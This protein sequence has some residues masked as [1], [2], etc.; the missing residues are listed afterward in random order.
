M[1]ILFVV[2]YTPTL[3]RA[4]SY[5]FI[6]VLVDRGHCVT[7]ATLWESE[8][9]RLALAE[10]ASQGIAVIAE[11]LTKPQILVNMVCALLSRS[12]IQASFSW[13]PGLAQQ[14]I[15]AVQSN[16]FDIIHVEHLRG[17]KY[18]LNLQS[19][20][21]ASLPPI[22]WDS[23]DCISYLF[24]QAS[25]QSRSAFG[26]II[27]RLELS[28]TRGFERVILEQLKYIIITSS[29]DRQALLDL[30][31][32]CVV[33][34][35]IAVIKNGVDLSYFCPDE[36]ITRDDASVVL[37]GKMS[38]HANVTM[39]SV[40]VNEIMPLVWKDRP[41]VQ[42]F[43]A[44]KDP[45]SNVLK[46]GKDKRVNVTGTVSDIRVFV[47]CATIA[48]VPLMY[49]AGSQFKVMEAMACGTPVVASLQAVQA[50][51]AVDGQDL[52]VADGSPAFA[53]AI[54]RLL[55]DPALQLRLGENGRNY[56]RRHHD[57]DAISA[58]LET[59]YEEAGRGLHI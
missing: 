48:V 3:I 2:P 23:V 14:L 15:R 41:E 19:A 7:L 49:G 37:S 4:R 53:N 10:L 32:S 44:G 52:L 43:L 56:V 16:S 42:V 51:Q 18:A 36:R 20:M 5:N 38:Y 35:K 50:L 22:V 21:G 9:D 26:R 45:R 30:L 33:P 11:H 59:V 54:V 13:H 40:L 39:A 58:Q 47:R 55:D 25:K 34:P 12:P 1:N 46:L 57:W 29:I 17:A 6:R 8:L 27:S 31:P 28:K 24:Q